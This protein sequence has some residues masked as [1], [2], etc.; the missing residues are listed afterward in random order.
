M[1]SNPNRKQIILTLSVV[2]GLA[3]G[4]ALAADRPSPFELARTPGTGHE[5]LARLAGSYDLTATFWPE[6]GAAPEVSQLPSRRELILGGRALR[7]EVGPD[8]DGFRGSGLMGFDNV[9]E[10]FWYV[11]TDTSTTG[12]SSLTGRLGA[13]GSGTLEGETPT[14]FGAAP[15]RVEIRFDGVEEVHEHYVPNGSGGEHRMLELRYRRTGS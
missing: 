1:A 8:A 7:L 14:P 4:A 15:L 10:S 2:V 12:M 6:P 5:T 13:A 11:W 3:S 9:A